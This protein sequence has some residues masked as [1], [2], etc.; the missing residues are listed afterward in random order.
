[1]ITLQ[2]VSEKAIS[3][4]MIEWFSQGFFS[5]VDVVL[6]DNT[7]LGARSDGGVAIRQ[8]GYARFNKRTVF[9]LPST[10]EQDALFY[11]FLHAQIGKPYDF[12]C[13]AAFVAG[14]D[15]HEDDSWICSELAAAAC[16]K[17]H[18]LPALY[19][20]A[21]KITPDSMAMAMSAAGAQVADDI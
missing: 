21:N 11:T 3:S 14:R 2:F 12:E 1:M 18:I 19:V 10:I 16:E 5:H 8:P 13:I 9:S 15:W 6:P 17:A 20:S 7:L 4:E